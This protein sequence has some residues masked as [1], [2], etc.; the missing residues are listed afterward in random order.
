MIP[1]KPNVIEF[2]TSVTDIKDAHPGG[3]DSPKKNHSRMKIRYSM[4]R[5]IAVPPRISPRCRGKLEKS[6]SC[7]ATRFKR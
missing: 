3:A 7:R 4:L 1:R 5:T 2:N 6:K